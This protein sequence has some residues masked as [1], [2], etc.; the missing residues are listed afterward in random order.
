[1]TDK[2]PSHY[3]A[4]QVLGTAQLGDTV[5]LDKNKNGKQDSG[6]PGI[7]GAKVLLKDASGTVIATATTTKGPWDGWYKF[8]G[9]DAGKYT[10]VLDLSSVSGELTTAGAFTVDLAEGQEYLLADFGVA[11]EL[12]KTGLDSSQMALLGFA[13]LGAGSIAVLAT[14]TRREDG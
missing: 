10:A 1:M 8:V 9:L 4:L 2:D 6:E 7:N 11:E 13:L 5:W 12:P 14:R 3:N